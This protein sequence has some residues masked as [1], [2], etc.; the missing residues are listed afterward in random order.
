MPLKLVEP[1]PGKTP[2]Y[3]I[4]GTYLGQPVNRTAGT[5]DRKTAQKALR[6]IKDEIERGVF[7]PKGAVTFAS[8]ALSYLRQGGEDTFI[9]RLADHFGATPLM[10]ID[11]EAIDTAA[12][13]LY[14]DASDAT[15]NRQVYTP[16]SAILKHAKM[17]FPLKRPKGAQG[18]RKTEWMTPDQAERLLDAAERKDAE[19]RVFLALLCYTGLRLGEALNIECKHVDLS[20]AMIFVPKTK[21]GDARAVHVP[22]SLKVELA[23]HPRGMERSGYLF[24]FRKNGH[25]YNLMR[26]AKTKAGLPS[27]TFHTCRHTWATWMRRYAKL[28]VKGLVGT[29]AWKDE[30]SAARYQ[31]VVVTEEAQRADMLP[32]LKSGKRGK[33]VD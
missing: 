22:P 12:H 18:T 3:S 11:Q 26:E 24:R 21:N 23:N 5:P 13:L 28:D 16:M 31:H 29:G 8:A 20:Q 1:R 30:K 9:D 17:S 4:R 33:S 27:I 2:N 7:A 14:P 10:L 32:V 6:K 19:F 15:R 25:L